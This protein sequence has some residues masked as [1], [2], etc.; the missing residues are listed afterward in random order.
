MVCHR[1]SYWVDS[2]PVGSLEPILLLLGD[3]TVVPSPMLKGSVQ[4]KKVHCL[5]ILVLLS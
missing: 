3:L 2:M 4:I 5:T 1:V